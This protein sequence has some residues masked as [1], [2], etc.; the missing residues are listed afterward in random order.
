MKKTP[1]EARAKYCI[2]RWVFGKPKK[3]ARRFY[4]F[5]L[6]FYLL[7]SLIFAIY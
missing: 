4:A 7:V 5:L 2:D 1:Y 3:K 6:I